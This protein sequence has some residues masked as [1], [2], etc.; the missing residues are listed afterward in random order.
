MAKDNGTSDPKQETVALSRIYPNSWNV[1][2]MP[3]FMY[4]KELASIRRYGFVD[5]ITVRP[6]PFEKGAY[7]IVDG[8]HRWRAA[9]E[10]GI[11]NVPVVIIDVDDETAQELGL[12]LNETRGAAN[13]IKLGGLVRSLIEKR[14]ES[15]TQVLPFT[16]E[17][18][19]EMVAEKDEKL[20]FDALRERSKVL[21]EERTMATGWSERVFRLH[22]DS[23]AVVDTAIERVK[24]TEGITEDWRALAVM[25]A[26][27]MKDD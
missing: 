13:P 23:P 19:A 15:V 21:K 7:Q 18:L 3:E 11:M 22:V 2:E 4:Q 8:E 9:S 5:P 1:N 27:S 16:P 10:L 24:E 12:V 25:A 6:H 17:R 20:D 14:G 26:D